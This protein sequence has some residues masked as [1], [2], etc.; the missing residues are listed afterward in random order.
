MLDGRELP[1]VGMALD[2]A[3]VTA[4]AATLAG[5]LDGT[6]AAKV[7][8][9]GRHRLRE[10][11]R[12]GFIEI[13]ACATAIGAGELY[14]PEAL[15]LFVDRVA[16]IAPTLDRPPAACVPVPRAS[17]DVSVPLRGLLAAIL[18]GRLHAVARTPGAGLGSVWV[19]VAEARR[20]ASPAPSVRRAAVELGLHYEAA[21]WLAAEG[22]LGDKPGVVKPGMVAVFGAAFCTTAQAARELRIP[23]R[24]VTARLRAAGG[25]PTFGP[26]SCRQ[27]IWRRDLLRT[28][29]REA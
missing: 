22:L 10:L 4:V 27:A 13:D 25:A 12:A 15:S 19:S 5:L 16:G 21:R 2:G 6:A 14:R 1:G 7:L 29:G 24:T 8:G 28:L 9:I 17:R 11:A 20:L 3:R 18:D 23:A 26:P